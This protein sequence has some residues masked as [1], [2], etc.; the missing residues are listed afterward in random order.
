M[1]QQLES[2]DIAAA[3]GSNQQSDQDSNGT[4]YISVDNNDDQ[5][6]KSEEEKEVD[7]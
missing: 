1:S 2:A 6:A 4:F 5:Q 3:M 7:K